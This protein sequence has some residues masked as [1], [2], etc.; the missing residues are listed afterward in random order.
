[1]YREQFLEFIETGKQPRNKT[2]QPR[3]SHIGND[4]VRFTTRLLWMPTSLIATHTTLLKGTTSQKHK[5][6]KKDHKKHHKWPPKTGHAAYMGKDP[7]RL[8]IDELKALGIAKE[9]DDLLVRRYRL[10]VLTGLKQY[11]VPARGRTNWTLL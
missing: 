5:D 10:V 3:Q 1:M 6:H 4:A 11:V 9:Y 8:L 2:K 7:L